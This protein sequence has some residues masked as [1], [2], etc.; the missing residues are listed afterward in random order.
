MRKM[1]Y[2]QHL[3]KCGQ[4]SEKERKSRPILRLERPKHFDNWDLVW[5]ARFIFS[6]AN[7]YAFPSI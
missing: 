4:D 6:S 2:D 5:K 7:A 1:A 3:S